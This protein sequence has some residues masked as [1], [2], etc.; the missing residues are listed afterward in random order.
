MRNNQ[1]A[2]NNWNF[3]NFQFEHYFGGVM[4][5]TDDN[6]VKHR[7]FYTDTNNYDLALAITIKYVALI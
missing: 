7:C 3:E 1:K 5:I 6:S 2:N 4:T